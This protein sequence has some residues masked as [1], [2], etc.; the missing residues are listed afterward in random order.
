MLRSMMVSR[1]INYEVKIRNDNTNVNSLIPAEFTD[2][3]TVPIIT[4]PENYFLTVTRAS[5]PLCTLPIHYFQIEEGLAQNDINK[6]L[7][8]LKFEND[9]SGQ[10]LEGNI[11]FETS[12]LISST[13]KPPSQ[14]N[15]NQA[16]S[17][18]YYVYSYDSIC[19]MINNTIINIFSGTGVPNNELPEVVFSDG[20]FSIYLYKSF[21]KGQPSYN[22]WGNIFINNIFLLQCLGT[23]PVVAQPDREY[24][25]LDQDFTIYFPPDQKLFPGEN[26]TKPYDYIKVDQKF[27]YAPQYLSFLSGIVVTSSKINAR[28][29]L[30]SSSGEISNN[31]ANIIFGFEP[32]T[33]SAGISQDKLIYYSPNWRFNNIV[34]LMGEE[35]LTELDFKIFIVDF[36]NRLIPLQVSYGNSVN[37][38][39]S[40]IHKDEMDIHSRKITSVQ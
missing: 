33:T 13:P 12:N 18:Y 22:G 28:K 2:Y 17:E 14:N 8:K 27:S 38:T 29:V 30:V 35:P 19:S 7:W 34:D 11:I 36:K 37:L 6:G 23:L 4:R 25:L 26:G 20:K 9:I 1:H 15:G 21:L 31:N 10:V 3:R 16:L 39:L 40:F 24:A 5:F 32:D